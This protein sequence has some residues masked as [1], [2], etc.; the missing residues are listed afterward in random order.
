MGFYLL[1]RTGSLAERRFP[2]PATVT[3]LGAGPLNDISWVDGQLAPEHAQIRWQASGGHVLVDLGSASGVFVNGERV[4]GERA[5][6]PGDRIRIAGETF[7]YLSMEDQSSFPR[8]ATAA[9]PPARSGGGNLRPMLLV[10]LAAL[11]LLAFF[12]FLILPSLWGFLL[13]GRVATA[14]PSPSPQP[15]LMLTA[16]TTPLPD[17]V[18]KFYPAPIP[19]GPADD[20]AA[21]QITLQW[22]WRG[23]LEQ[24]EWYEVLVWTGDLPPR[25]IA[26][27]RIPQIELGISQL[28]PGR[29]QWQVVVVQGANPG[30]K[31]RELSAASEARYFVLLPPTATPTT[32]PTA[33][34]TPSATLTATKTPAPFL[35]LMISGI[36]Y[37]AQRGLAAPLPN[38][39]VRIYIGEQRL[40]TRTDSLG[41]YVAEFRLTN[42]SVGQRADMLVTLAG[43]QAGVA[44]IALGAYPPNVAQYLRLDLGLT[45][46]PTLTPSPSATA[47]V[48]HTPLPTYTPTPSP[49]VM[50]PTIAFIPTTTPTST[51]VPT[52]RTPTL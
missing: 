20:L 47:T 17:T 24:D 36:I 18:S 21:P 35:W 40:I 9:S 38:A 49:L 3:T 16:T 31:Q 7:I 48:T 30:Q 27:V 5:L 45:L 15:A 32:R 34:P 39:E 22:S 13:A 46:S 2:L 8:R 6:L 26:W 52:T 44:N 23:A 10:L 51:S 41:K 19:L 37:D 28:P 43:Y 42:V 33:T 50:T 1:A 4:S 12:A 29:Y 25:S 14:P 11:I